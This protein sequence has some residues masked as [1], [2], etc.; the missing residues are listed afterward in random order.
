M[1]KW[2][3]GALARAAEANIRG[4][5][6]PVDVTAVGTDSRSLPPACLFVA[7]RGDRFDGHTFIPEVIKGGARAVMVDQRYADA[8]APLA[9]PE[10][11][12][13]DTLRGLGD[14][15]AWIRRQESKP[16]VAVTGSNGKTTT[17]EMIAA[18]LCE[19]APTHKTEGNLNNLIGLPLTIARWPENAWAAVLEMGMNAKGEISRLTT[20]A[21]PNV[22]V[23]TCVGPAHLE[24]LGTID[25]VAKAKGELFENLPD[26]ATAVVNADDPIIQ[27]ICVPMLGKKRQIRFGS[28]RGSDVRVVRSE[29]SSFGSRVHIAIEGAEIQIRLPLVGG[30]NAN[31]AAA[32]AA[33]AWALGL[34]RE[35][36]AEGLQKVRVPGGRLRVVRG[37]WGGCHVLD[38][39]YNANPQSMRAAFA[40]LAEQSE[41][42]RIAVLGDMFELGE[43]SQQLHREVGRA[44]AESGIQLILALGPQASA[45][46]NG[47]REAGAKAEAFAD[48]ADLLTTL[49]AAIHREDWI[50]VKGSRSMRMERVVEDLGAV[51]TGG[52]H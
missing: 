24:G 9:V 13:T 45:T 3:L 19:R 32:A 23:I 16:V 29:P 48:L 5:E 34:H 38:D 36:I 39:T 42:R 44:A 14:A 7:L 41:G 11:V 40:A 27:G 8:H 47:A 43:E 37:A 25:A 6:L 51:E 52:G 15:A 26:E 30:H 33:A 21:Q 12:V 46:A 35:E 31:N 2:D 17:K 49:R 22:G 50:L 20:I 10:L 18:I 28:K 4:G 1:K